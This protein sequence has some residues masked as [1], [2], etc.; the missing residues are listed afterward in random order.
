MSSSTAPPPQSIPLAQHIPT[1]IFLTLTV[2]TSTLIHRAQPTPYIDEIFHI[3]QAQ[4]FCSALPHFSTTSVGGLWER[5]GDVE[6]DSK[7]TTP[8]GLYAISVGLAKL[9]PGWRCDDVAWLRSTNLAM[10]LTLPVLVG[11]ILRQN[12]AQ[13]E[14]SS[15]SI[16]ATLLLVAP[17]KAE[18]VQKKAVPRTEIQTLQQKA[19]TEAPPTPDGPNDDQPPSVPI[20][21]IAVGERREQLTLPLRAK[22]KEATPYDMA[23][24]STI[25]FLP[26]LWFFGFLYYTDV[27]SVWL[28][29]ACL[30]LFNDLDPSKSTV[31][32][33]IL[34]ALTSILAVMVRQTNLVWVMYCAGRATLTAIQTLQP[35]RNRG[36]E[37]LV[38]ELT[39][40]F[41]T[42]TRREFG[43]VVG[44]NLFPLLPMLFGCIAFIRWNGSIVLGD[45]TNHQAGLHLPQLGYFL[46]FSSFFALFPLL[47]T[48][49]TPPSSSRSL[50]SI[51]VKTSMQAIKTVW[52]AAFGSPTKTA[53]FTVLFTLAWAGV[54]NFIID[55]PF[56]LADNRHYTFYLWRIFRRPLRLGGGTMVLQ[57]RFLAVPAYVFAVYAWGLALGN[58][59]NGGLKGVLLV[60]AVVATLV[61]SPLV[62]VRYYLIPY[63]LLRLAIEA[64]GGGD[65]RRDGRVRWMFLGLEL[66]LYASVN[67]VTV[68]LFAGRSF[69]WAPE[70]VDVSRGESTIMRFI[71]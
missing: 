65:G 22:R 41:K 39:R 6:Y 16:P 67:A 35:E 70:A 28:T 36:D 4:L 30:T 9:L 21:T 20:P 57:P 3:P 29:L 34:L 5:L 63:I 19:K 71:W 54:D 13:Q 56:L 37:G 7:L 26:P 32:T 47:H 64:K 40:L 53:V 42:V 25:A 8:P 1:L 44:K 62:E 51:L 24:A 10:V 48:F 52:D 11:R 46:L 55:H 12:E 58:R 33:S 66:G 15:P 18:W 49:Y 38:D 43:K 45:K 68:V 59:G 31:S 50:P 60:G 27:A 2:L 23:L 14:S 17:T 69:E 61:P